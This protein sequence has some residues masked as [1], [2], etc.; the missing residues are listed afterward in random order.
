MVCAPA[1]LDLHPALASELQAAGVEL[2]V[3]D[4]AP[5]NVVRWR[6]KLPLTDIYQTCAC[7]FALHLSRAAECTG[8]QT[9]GRSSSS[10]GGVHLD[11]AEREQMP[12]SQFIERLQSGSWETG[13]QAQK[14]QYGADAKVLSCLLL[15]Q[16]TPN[17]ADVRR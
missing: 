17:A 10:F 5:Q 4:A 2:D 15:A 12:A 11:H 7:V 6:R 16:P 8:S 13:V 1:L 14:H 3:S 9:S